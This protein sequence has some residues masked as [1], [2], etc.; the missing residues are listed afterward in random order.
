MYDADP[1][2][3]PEATRF[4]RIGYTD[5][6]AH[7]LQALDSTAVSLAMDNEMPIVVFDMTQTGNILRA[8]RGEEIGTLITGEVTR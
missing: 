5:L 1:E 6:L 4:R 3:H 8:I 7:R 2:L